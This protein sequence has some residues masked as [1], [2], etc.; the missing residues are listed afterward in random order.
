MQQLFLWYDELYPTAHH[1]GISA[2]VLKE[3]ILFLIFQKVPKHSLQ[4][5]VI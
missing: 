1:G 2:P 3:L 5:E 4:R